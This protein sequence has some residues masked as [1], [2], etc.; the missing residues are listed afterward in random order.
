MLYTLDGANPFNQQDISS[1]TTANVV[2]FAGWWVYLRIQRRH[3]VEV[4]GSLVNV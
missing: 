3:L 4:C 2:P 1:W